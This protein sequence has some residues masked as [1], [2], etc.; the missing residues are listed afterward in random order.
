MENGNCEVRGRAQ[1]T[2]LMGL[3]FDQYKIHGI[4]QTLRGRARSVLY[5]R[6][7]ISYKGQERYLETKKGNYVG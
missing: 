7:I 3:N 4:M 6:E 2:G 5:W 1:G